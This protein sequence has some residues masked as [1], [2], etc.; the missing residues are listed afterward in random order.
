MPVKITVEHTDT[1][2]GDA[3]YAWLNR[4]NL[5]LKTDSRLAIIRAAK[6]AC[7]FTGLSAKVSDFGDMIEIRPR[8]L[9]QIAF[10][11]FD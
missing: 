9:C 3:N 6:K 7:G 2:G 8:G 11:T 4:H 5:E 10:I 1:F